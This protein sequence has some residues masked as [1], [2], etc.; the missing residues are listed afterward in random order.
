MREPIYP[1][2]EPWLRLPSMRDH[3]TPEERI[4]ATAWR[5]TALAKARDFLRDRDRARADCRHVYTNAA[6]RTVNLC[7]RTLREVE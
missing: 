7:R 3:V 1:D 2:D 5:R 4:A 6:G